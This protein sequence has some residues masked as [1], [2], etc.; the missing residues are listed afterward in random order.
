MY[1][2]DEATIVSHILQGKFSHGDFCEVYGRGPEAF[3][4]KHHDEGLPSLEKFSRQVYKEIY[5]LVKRG[6]FTADLR[7]ADLDLSH[8]IILVCEELF[9][10][11]LLTPGKNEETPEN[12]PSAEAWQKLESRYG[13]IAGEELEAALE[14]NELPSDELPDMKTCVLLGIAGQY[15]ILAANKPIGFKLKGSTLR[16]LHFGDYVDA[17]IIQKLFRLGDKSAASYVG[18][19]TQKVVDAFVAGRCRNNKNKG[20]INWWKERKGDVLSEL[21]ER[22]SALLPAPGTTVRSTLETFI[23]SILTKMAKGLF[24]K[25]NRYYSRYKLGEPEKIRLQEDENEDNDKPEDVAEEL[26]WDIPDFYESLYRV[27]SGS[28]KLSER[29]RE[30]VELRYLAGYDNT[31]IGKRFGLDANAAGSLIYRGLESIRRLICADVKN[32]N[33]YLDICNGK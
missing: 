19:K 9:L 24:A 11:H 13:A 33:I 20:E 29:H 16:S 18:K 4:E 25:D 5:A 26:Y 8:A 21:Y 17:Q 1:N 10:V 2:P 31:S 15:K 27:A 14:V 12:A 23:G 28:E 22:V 6:N 3:W 32:K 7:A 30:A